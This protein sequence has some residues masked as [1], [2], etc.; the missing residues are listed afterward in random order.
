MTVTPIFTA[1]NGKRSREDYCFVVKH[2]RT[3]MLATTRRFADRETAERERAKI[4][5]QK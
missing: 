4:L 3:G 1:A 5:R 2:G